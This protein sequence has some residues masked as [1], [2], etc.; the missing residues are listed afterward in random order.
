MKNSSHNLVHEQGLSQQ[1]ELRLWDESRL[2]FDILRRS[3]N[4]VYVIEQESYELLYA[5]NEME[6]I[7]AD[8]G[9]HNYLSKKCYCALRHLDGPCDNCFATAGENTGESHEVY[10][11]FLSKYYSVVS[12]SIEWQGVPAYVIY[13]SDI[14]EEKKA[15]NEITQI[16]NNIPGAV[17]RCKFDD[18]WTVISANDGLFEFLGY[19]K[20][21][22][23]AMGNKMSAVTHPE[24]LPGILH[25]VSAQLVKGS[26][27]V[28]HEQ[29]LICKDG[30]VK[31]VLIRGQLLENPEEG[32]NFY[33][34]FVDISEQK[35]TQFE[36]SKTQKKLAA[37]IDHAGLAYWE[38]DFANNR[39][40]L[41]AIS[42]TEYTLDEVIENYPES[43]YRSGA[44]H[45]DSIERY[46]LLVQAVK[47]GEPTAN[48]DIKTIDAKGDLVWK[49][50]RFT[51]LFDEYDKPFWA[52]ATAE[53]I[54][55]YKELEGRF[56]TV[57]EQNNIDT[58]MYDL[59]R[60]TIIQ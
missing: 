5:N 41:N 40:Y 34:V 26:T 36:L 9:I 38:Y 27:S 45:P 14:S 52:V 20:E 47:R 39:A 50:V 46:D 18:H 33:C 35:K 8:V 59:P 58:W 7:F 37:A 4:G 21:E 57:L 28:E 48:A 13:L 56:S 54:N 2:Y 22:F 12:Y 3:T 60:H 53:S 30:T 43:L 42:T 17:F 6:Q 44:I 32:K 1:E 24:D 10:L 51:T 55:E 19:T 23:T 25:T 11:D 49:R 31:W 15:A 29:R 16:Y